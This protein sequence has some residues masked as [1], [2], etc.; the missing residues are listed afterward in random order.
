MYVGI[1]LH[2][3][4]GFQ[5]YKK[6]K[7]SAL[8]IEIWNESHIISEPFQTFIFQLYKVLHGSFSKHTKNSKGKPK[9]H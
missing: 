9:I 7:F 3:Q 4:L 6:N 2:T 5:R 8:N 1:S